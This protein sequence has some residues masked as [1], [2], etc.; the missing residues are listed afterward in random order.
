MRKSPFT[1][2]TSTSVACSKN[3][4]SGRGRTGMK[5]RSSSGFARNRNLFSKERRRVPKSTASGQ[6][7]SLDA[8][9]G[10]DL[11]PSARRLLHKKP[12]WNGG[13]SLWDA[14]SIFYEM[15]GIPCDDRPSARTLVLL[16][17][18]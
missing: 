14:S 17:A 9:R 11:V 1:I 3:C 5:R 10:R 8:V 2:N 13:F 12:K 16:Y 6:L 18:A 7:I 4:G 15:H